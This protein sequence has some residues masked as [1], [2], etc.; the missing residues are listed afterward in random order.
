[1]G[2]RKEEERR[3]GERDGRPGDTPIA[4]KKLQ[5]VSPTSDQQASASI[6]LE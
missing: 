5:A 2:T 1:M 3:G 6:S 4:T